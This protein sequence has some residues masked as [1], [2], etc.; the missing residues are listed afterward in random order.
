MGHSEYR[1]EPPAA[2]DPSRPVSFHF[3]SLLTR[4]FYITSSIPSPPY[5]WQ[6]FSL[7]QWHDVIIVTRITERR[8]ANLQEKSVPLQLFVEHQDVRVCLD[9]LRVEVH[10]TKPLQT[11]CSGQRYVSLSALKHTG[12]RDLHTIQS[13]ALKHT[14][15]Q[16]Q[17]KRATT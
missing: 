9:H 16:Q 12:Q 17:C 10:D 13:H 7:E 6:S 5:L 11:A 15:Q 3:S 4:D 2:D 8:G 14:Q 1:I